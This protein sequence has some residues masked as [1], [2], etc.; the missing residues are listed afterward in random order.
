MT[1]HSKDGHEFIGLR[2]LQNGHRHIVYDA[3]SGRRVV[4][5]VGDRTICAKIIDEAL[6]EGIRAAR[7]LP[8]VLTALHK[9]NIGFELLD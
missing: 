9:R 4:V 6:Q 3:A 1:Y 7:V 5:K 2:S 8:G